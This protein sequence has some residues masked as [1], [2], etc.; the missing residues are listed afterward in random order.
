MDKFWDLF[1]ESIIMQGLITLIVIGST[2]YLIVTSQPVPEL[3]QALV[4]LV[5]GFFFGAKT[6][7]ASTSGY[8]SGYSDGVKSAAKP[9]PSDET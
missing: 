9:R 3:M 4:T 1:K 6:T 8:V 7:K 2:C 5:V